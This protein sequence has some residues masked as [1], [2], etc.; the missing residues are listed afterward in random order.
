MFI[1]GWYVLIDM[2]FC[3]GLLMMFF[4]G[5]Y[6][7]LWILYLCSG[8]RFFVMCLCSGWVWEVSW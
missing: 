1:L 3:F 6:L 5:G 7:N 2:R 4:D 8:V